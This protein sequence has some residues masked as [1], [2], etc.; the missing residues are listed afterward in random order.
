[1]SS[2]DFSSP[3]LPE[4][5]LDASLQRLHREEDISASS[6]SSAALSHAW[7][8][9]TREESE[10]CPESSSPLFPRTEV[11]EGERNYAFRFPPVAPVHDSR[12]P[13]PTSI[14]PGTTT[15]QEQPALPSRPRTSRGLSQPKPFLSSSSR[16]TSIASIAEVED[17]QGKDEAAGPQ[18]VFGTPFA[19]NAFGRG[20]DTFGDDFSDLGPHDRARSDSSASDGSRD[21]DSAFS[22]KQADAPRLHASSRR[23]EQRRPRA[24]TDSNGSPWTVLFAPYSQTET[25]AQEDKLNTGEPSILLPLLSSLED[26]VDQLKSHLSKSHEQRLVDTSDFEFFLDLGSVSALPSNTQARLTPQSWSFAFARLVSQAAG[27]HESRLTEPLPYLYRETGLPI[28]AFVRYRLLPRPVQHRPSRAALQEIGITASQ[29]NDAPGLKPGSQLQASSAWTR[30][31]SE[32]T[33]SLANT[34]RLGT[35]PMSASR[36]YPGNAPRTPVRRS[37]L[38]YSPRTTAFP[39]RPV[40]SSAINPTAAAMT[41]LSNRSAEAS[42]L[43]SLSLAAAHPL[44]P[45]E[46]APIPSG[47]T[48]RGVEEDQTTSPIQPRYP[49]SRGSSH[50]SFPSHTTS[51]STHSTR[52]TSIYSIRTRLARAASEFDDGEDEDAQLGS[53]FWTQLSSLG[54]QVSRESKLSRARRRSA[55][56]NVSISSAASDASSVF[57]FSPLGILVPSERAFAT[58][59]QEDNLAQV[60]SVAVEGTVRGGWQADVGLL[61]RRRAYSSMVPLTGW[62]TGDSDMLT[63]EG[64]RSAAVGDLPRVLL[65][66]PHPGIERDAQPNENADLITPT[67]ATFQ[68]RARALSFQPPGTSLRSASDPLHAPGRAR[69][70]VWEEAMHQLSE[71]FNRPRPPPLQQAPIIDTERSPTTFTTSDAPPQKTLPG[72]GTERGEERSGVGSPAVESSPLP[73]LFYDDWVER[74]D[75]AVDGELGRRGSTF[76]LSEQPQHTGSVFVAPPGDMLAPDAAGV[77]GMSRTSSTS[78]GSTML[79]SV[80]SEPSLQVLH[81][82]EWPRPQPRLIGDDTRVSGSTSFLSVSSPRFDESAS[83]EGEGRSSVEYLNSPSEDSAGGVQGRDADGAEMGLEPVQLSRAPIISDHPRG[84]GAVIQR[85]GEEGLSGANGLMVGWADLAQRLRSPGS[86]R[87]LCLAAASWSPDTGASLPPATA[88]LGD[89]K[90]E[91]ALP[92]GLALPAPLSSSSLTRSQSLSELIIN[93]DTWKHELREREPGKSI[94]DTETQT[95]EV[96]ELGQPR[97]LTRK[98]AAMLGPIRIPSAE[99]SEQRG[100]ASESTGAGLG[101]VNG[102]APRPV[103]RVKRS[104][105]NI[106]DLPSPVGPGVRPEPL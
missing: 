30:R 106:F 49:S 59:P 58:D 18:I 73:G 103:T 19:G 90:S 84:G 41:Q 12:G 26:Q 2:S 11:V 89:T 14:S 99:M 79:G 68:G 65:V 8:L 72:L 64:Q 28:A 71:R 44:T 36:S 27:G 10:D 48:C 104:L 23:T 5:S 69:Q 102:L 39:V 85:S 96:G 100:A 35:S 67:V 63:P 74:V 53:R 42:K 97:R 86:M 62:R 31:E 77:G 16:T 87:L 95:R 40:L 22:P 80:G 57:D 38:P 75:G 24:G 91:S 1:M 4:L 78:S 105:S 94:S 81:E 92:T 6:V 13:S 61:G 101:A 88:E 83:G 76:D 55:S 7:R 46:R 34:G 66:D 15:F 43:R 33:V 3:A 47:L 93:I 70:D 32:M 45:T 9:R 60:S 50:K 29:R 20:L 25:S 56:R 37:P 17:G 21:F 54:E 52:S 51:L 82:S 98:K